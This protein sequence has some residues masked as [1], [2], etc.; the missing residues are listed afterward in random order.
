MFLEIGCGTGGY[1]TYISS[2]TG[3]RAIGLDVSEVAIAIAQRS[4]TPN[5]EFLCRDARNTGLPD[6][7]AGAALAIDTLDLAGDHSSLLSEI[8]RVLV[9]GAALVFTALHTGPG[10]EESIRAWSAALEAKGFIA[11]SVR[12]ISEDWQRHMLAKHSWRWRRR[13]RLRRVL[14]TWVE[15][16]LSVSA[17]MLGLGSAVSV[18]RNTSRSEFVACVPEGR[19]RC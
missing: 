10:V 9:P 6:C 3:A 1:G 15:P 12:D 8:S 18:A 17:A 5:V 16:E 14:G 2:R 11:V 7:C 4:K 19:L 13:D